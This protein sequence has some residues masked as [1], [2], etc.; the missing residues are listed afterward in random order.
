MRY[1]YEYTYEY[2][3]PANQ[4]AEAGVLISIMLLTFTVIFLLA[5]V[6]YIFHSIGLYT[7]GKRLGKDYPWLA[8]IPFARNYFHGELAG[9][10][11]LKNRT[12]KNPGIW[13]LILPII[14]STLLGIFV[15]LIAIIGSLSAATAAAGIGGVGIGLSLIIGMYIFLIMFAIVMSAVRM[16]L[17]VLINRQIFGRFTCGNMAVV[18]SVFSLTVPLYEAF[19]LFVMRNKEFDGDMEQKTE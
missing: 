14:E 5:L 10:I 8:F 3:Y 12:I 15:F 18:Y 19:C 4:G 16:A 2:D 9:E 11:T 1:G 17:S 6:S 7:I 13:N